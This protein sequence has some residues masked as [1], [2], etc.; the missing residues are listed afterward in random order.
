VLL[1]IPAVRVFLSFVTE[2]SLALIVFCFGFP[3][4]I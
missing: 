3:P 1:Q 4:M 2:S